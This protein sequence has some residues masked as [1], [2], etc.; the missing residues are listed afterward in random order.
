M[1]AKK[2]ELGTRRSARAF[3]GRKVET[4]LP[5][6]LSW[7]EQTQPYAPEEMYFSAV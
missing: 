4:C 6:V 7:A 5:V 2:K 3:C 1:A